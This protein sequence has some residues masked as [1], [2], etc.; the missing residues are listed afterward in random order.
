MAERYTV[1]KVPELSPLASEIQLSPLAFR[2]QHHL[3]WRMREER[4]PILNE[5]FQKFLGVSDRAIRE[6]IA[7]LND[8]GVLALN[9]QN[10][11]FIST[12]PADIEAQCKIYG[13]HLVAYA[14]KIAALKRATIAS[15]LYSMWKDEEQNI[16]TNL[17]ETAEG[18]K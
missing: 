11:Y 2:I 12:D 16:Q 7:E 15:V 8:A 18:L 1:E 14:K 3:L 9:H 6:A 5:D 13:S 10:G 17:A 4:E